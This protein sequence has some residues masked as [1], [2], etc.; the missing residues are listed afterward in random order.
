[1]W[2]RRKWLPYSRGSVKNRGFDMVTKSGFIAF[3]FVFFLS[4]CTSS[5]TQEFFC[6]SY[7][8]ENLSN[9]YKQQIIRL[10]KQQLC[11]TWPVDASVC[12]VA[13]KPVLTAWFDDRT[14]LG[15][16]RGHLQTDF[17]SKQVSLDI[18][19]FARDKG[20]ASSGLPVPNAQLHFVFRPSEGSLLLT[21]GNQDSQ[22]SEFVCK[23]WIKQRWWGIY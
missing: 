7:A 5:D 11:V 8:Q 16:I 6:E 12:G 2:V 23:P 21:P 10:G 13:G 14:R 9:V 19:P 3:I 17:S 18:L 22:T 15:Q 20:D 4:A 1:M